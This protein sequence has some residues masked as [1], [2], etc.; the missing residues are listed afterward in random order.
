MSWYYYR[1]TGQIHEAT[2]VLKWTTDREIDL[3]KAAADV[4]VPQKVYG[5][6][7]TQ[8]QAETFKAGNPSWVD[9]AKQ[10]AGDVG[11]AVNGIPNAVTNFGNTLVKLVNRMLEAFAGVVLLAIAANVILK[12]VSGVDVAAKG[13]SAGKKAAKAAAA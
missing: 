5:P 9:Q 2:G 1:N 13:L 11:Q 6:F 4:G 12:Q 8:Q 3:E 10:A 7:A